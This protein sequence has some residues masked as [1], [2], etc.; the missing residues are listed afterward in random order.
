VEHSLSHL[1]SSSLYVPYCSYH[2]VISLVPCPKLFFLT[3]L[4]STSH[5]FSSGAG[6]TSQ[7]CHTFQLRWRLSIIY[8]GIYYPTWSKVC[9]LMAIVSYVIVIKLLRCD[10]WDGLADVKCGVYSLIWIMFSLWWREVIL[11]YV[12]MFLVDVYRRCWEYVLCILQC[13][14]ILFLKRYVSA[15]SVLEVIDVQR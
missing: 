12:C 4:D 6:D 2:S 13:F 1:L 3:P 15:H 8:Q 9:P 11:Q 5:D 7:L 14:I 10:M